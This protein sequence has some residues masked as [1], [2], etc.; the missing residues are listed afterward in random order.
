MQEGKAQ[1]IHASRVTRLA[2]LR[3]DSL[4]GCPYA[5]IVLSKHEWWNPPWGG[6]HLL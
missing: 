1:N 4:R 5:G 3:L 6:A 2:S